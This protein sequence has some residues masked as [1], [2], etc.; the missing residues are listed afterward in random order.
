MK[1]PFLMAK[2]SEKS[3]SLIQPVTMIASKGGGRGSRVTKVMSC[4]SC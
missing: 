4:E 3:G 1:T 2:F